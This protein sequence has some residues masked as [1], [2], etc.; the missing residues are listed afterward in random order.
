[1]TKK[2]ILVKYERA[3]RT[4]KRRT[5]IRSIMTGTILI[6]AILNYFGVETF[7]NARLLLFAVIFL[8]LIYSYVILG[9]KKGAS[10]EFKDIADFYMQNDEEINNLKTKK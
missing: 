2:E 1:M 6:T 7:S 3:V 9:R 8:F 10:K 4:Q 5:I